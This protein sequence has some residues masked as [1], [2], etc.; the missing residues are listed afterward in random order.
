MALKRTNAM[1]ELLTFDFDNSAGRVIQREGEPWFVAAD[2]AAILDYR[3]APN[4]VRNLDEDEA[5][6]HNVSS[7]GQR[8]EMSIISES[9]LFAAILKS[10]KPE[11]RAFRRWV[12]GT[13]LPAL[14]RTGTYRMG[15]DPALAIEHDSATLSS[16]IAVVR[17][18]RRLFGHQSAR[19]I[20]MKL[21]L[22]VP[23]AEG[24]GETALDPLAAA[25]VDYLTEA[26]AT[27]IEGAALALGIDQLD[28]STR[29]RIG[30]LLRFHGWF[31]AKVRQGRHT[32][33]L[34]TPRN[35]GQESVQ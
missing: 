20:W 5:A 14:R 15:H 1:T 3:D 27:T 29:Y 2:V 23:I 21:G 19:I 31:P 7:S 33:N 26:S 4:M 10:R 6:T 18:A 30:Q 35:A 32:V 22:P 12:T 8:R 34:F 24:P 16:A 9:G 13:V 25:L 28:N 11:A 17:E